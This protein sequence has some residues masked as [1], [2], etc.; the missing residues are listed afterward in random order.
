MSQLYSSPFSLSA[1]T[2]IEVTVSATNAVGDSTPSPV[3][4]VGQT[5]QSVPV[6][7]PTITRG[8]STTET[9]I[10]MDWNAIATSGKFSSFIF[11]V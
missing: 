9:A 3:N 5:I 4:T 8:A 1:G 7:A 2:L 6:V 11:D 10:Y